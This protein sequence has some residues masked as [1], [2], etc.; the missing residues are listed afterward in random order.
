[1]SADAA[2]EEGLSFSPRF[3]TDGLLPVVAQDV[4]TGAVLMLAYANETAIEATLRTG[5][6]HYWSRS[7]AELWRK[8]ATSG[9]VQRVVEVLTDCDQD[10]LVY[11]VQQAGSACHT[12]RA[13]C[14]YRRLSGPVDRDDP[15][16]AVQLEFTS[17]R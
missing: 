6:A 17:V 13:S 2:I 9:D 4:G 5:E 14:F 8:G 10:A 16:E 1:M 15:S 12:G 11:R 7:R 3:G